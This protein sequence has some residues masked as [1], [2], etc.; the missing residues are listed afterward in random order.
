M[1]KITRESE[2]AFKG[3]GV[4]ERC[5]FCKIESAYWTD[6]N[7]CVCEECARIKNQ[8][9]LIKI[10]NNETNNRKSKSK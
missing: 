5:V 8:F 2:E 4:Y 10:K 6:C 3:T 7:E 1:I 9:D